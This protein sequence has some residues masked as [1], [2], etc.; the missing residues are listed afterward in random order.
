MTDS[1]LRKLFVRTRI[2]FDVLESMTWACSL[3][4]TATPVPQ[5]RSSYMASSSMQESYVIND[6]GEAERHGRSPGRGQA[7]WA[8]SLRETA[9]P[10]PQPRSSYMASSS[11]QGSNGRSPTLP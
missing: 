8:C 11:M 1:Q 7:T 2:E 5:P 10:V 4:E 6:M 3:R 9:T